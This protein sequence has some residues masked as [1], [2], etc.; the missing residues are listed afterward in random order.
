MKIAAGAWL[1]LGVVLAAG[2]FA[3]AGID[4]AGMDR[5]V[6]AGNNFYAYANGAWIAATEIPPDR[7]SVVMDDIIGDRT[8]IQIAAIVQRAA[9]TPAPTGSDQ[10]LVGDYYAAFMDQ[11]GI[12]MRGLRPLYTLRTEI[13]AISDRHELARFLGETIR[14]DVDVLNANNVVTDDL[15]GLWIAQ[16]F[17]HPEHYVPFLLQG[18]LG[19]P[20]RSYY[21]DSDAALAEV[22]AKYAIHVSAML[23]LAGVA[24]PAARAQK[25]VELEQRI[26]TVHAS[27]T[28]TEDLSTGNNR[29]QREDFHKNAPGLDWEVFFTAAHLPLNQH[30]FIVWQPAAVAGISALVAS[31][32]LSTWKDYLYLR[33]IERRANCLPKAFVDEH[34]S[35]F[36]KNLEGEQTQRP[37]WKRAIA[38]TDKALGDAVGRLYI[39]GNFQ[40]DT[41]ARVESMVEQLRGA[42]SRRI[43]Q[44]DWMAPATKANAQAR[45]TQLKVGVAYPDQW[46]DYAGLRILRD[47]AYGNAERAGLFEYGHQL[48]KLGRKVDRSEWVMTPQKVDAVNLPAMNAINL[49][50]AELQ[51]PNFDPN[52]DPAQNYGALGATIGHEISHSFDDQGA[53]FDANNRLDTWWTEADLAHFKAAGE[54]LVAQYDRY[55]ALPDLAINGRLTLSENIA[56][57]VGLLVALDAYHQEVQGHSADI[58]DGFSG[59]QRFFIAYAQSFRAKVREQALRRQLLDDGHAPDEYRAL[60]LRNLDAWYEAFQVKPG[61]AQYL[62]PA[63]RVRIW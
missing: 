45:L 48:A 9:K 40:P 28:V 22:R 4:I 27:R 14:A 63:E 2:A 53:R 25:I 38:A 29:W 41:K 43:E 56:D 10:R 17:D 21:L 7:G 11:D 46:R 18:G 6:T 60:T 49:A 50:A 54:R 26:A 58:V 13:Q 36:G 61:Q 44:L 32:P 15:F 33:A 39:A 57:L 31:E 47:D 52:G 24:K 16:D 51:P 12:E 34:F 35:F 20:D 42:F 5:S 8:E 3:G 55:Q 62:A 59:D 30:D 23:A 1:A 19:M 37:R